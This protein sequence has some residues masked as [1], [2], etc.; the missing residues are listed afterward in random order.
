MRWSSFK[1]NHKKLSSGLFLLM[2]SFWVLFFNIAI[3]LFNWVCESNRK[4]SLREKPLQRDSSYR[5][6]ILTKDNN[7]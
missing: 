2:G 6:I 5:I 1:E 7:S 4:L 3:I